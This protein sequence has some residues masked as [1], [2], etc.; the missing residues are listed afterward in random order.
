MPDLPTTTADTML[1]AELTAGTTYYLS[2]HSASPGTTGANEIAVTRQPIVFAAASGGSMASTDAQAFTGVPA[3]SVVGA[4][5]WTA[6]TGGTYVAGGSVSVNGG[7][8]LA[9]GSTVNFAAGALTAG[10]S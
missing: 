3:V 8:A 6:A 10:V 9:A 1:S 7:A 4:G 2:I 5:I